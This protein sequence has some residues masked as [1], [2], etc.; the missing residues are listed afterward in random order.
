MSHRPRTTLSM[1]LAVL[2]ALVAGPTVAPP[3]AHAEPPRYKCTIVPGT[4]VANGVNKHGE[5]VGMMAFEAPQPSQAFHYKAGRL[6]AFGQAGHSTWAYAISD[7]GHIAGVDVDEVDGVGR[8]MMADR[9]GNV[10]VMDV[11]DAIGSEALAINDAMQ[12]VGYIEGGDGW[13]RAAMWDAGAFRD[14]SGG[15]DWNSYAFGINNLGEI[16]GRDD[17]L[18]WR[19]AYFDPDPS[20]MGAPGLFSAALGISDSGY[21]AGTAAEGPSSFA[22]VY[23]GSSFQIIATGPR[24]SAGA[25]D[26]NNLGQVVGKANGEA[27]LWDQGTHH[28]LASL[29]DEGACTPTEARSINDC[30]VIVGRAAEGAFMMVPIDGTDHADTDGDG[31][32]DRWER[33]GLDLDAD[34][35]PEF[36]PP[37]ADPNHADLYLELDHVAVAPLQPEVQ[38]ALVNAFA[39]VPVADLPSPNPDGKPGITLHFL[40]D[41]TNIPDEEEDHTIGDCVSIG[42]TCSY[43]LPG[44]FDATKE[45]FF[46][47]EAERNDPDPE[48]ISEAKRQVYH[49]VL[50]VPG[51]YATRADPSRHYISGV[52]ECHGNDFII[53]TKAFS[54]PAGSWQEQAGSLMHELG[55]NLGLRHGGDDDMNYK[56]NYFS[57]MNYTWQIPRPGMSLEWRLDYSRSDSNPTVFETI[58][59]ER[60]GLA[61]ITRDGVSVPVYIALDG[62]PSRKTLAWTD[63]PD[64]D[65]NGNGV[66][67]TV[68]V[69]VDI[70]NVDPDFV[71]SPQGRHTDYDDWAN[72]LLN[73]RTSPSFPE[74][75]HFVCSGVGDPA[76]SSSLI[77]RWLR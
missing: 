46:G 3:A 39:Q 29:I 66:I 57:V 22:W 19:A 74:G 24:G 71:P 6:I 59:D 48:K 21:V 76:L 35:A 1:A 18:G 61:G 44:F 68:N 16:V 36:V 63:V 26:V 67:D 33:C 58:L 56:A 45:V 53:G 54:A 47:T 51:L 31:L 60:L 65:F 25:N 28:P 34:G 2:V 42:T 23:D 15:H 20:D 43:N 10:T 52:S 37:D 64:V 27:F 17:A 55:H 69:D 38:G 32:K 8:A 75:V 72:I 62:D 7:A 70:N 40:I 11:G 30:G 5:V 13:N 12:A 50:M 77:Q 14:I 9:A 49:Y 73:F 4:F 41:D